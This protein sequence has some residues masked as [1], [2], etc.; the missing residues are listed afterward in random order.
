[1]ASVAQ[2]NRKTMV[3]VHTGE[4]WEAS[5]IKTREVAYT[6]HCP[7]CK[8]RVVIPMRQVHSV[9]CFECMVV[10][11]PPHIRHPDKSAL[12]EPI[13]RERSRRGTR[14]S[15]ES[16]KT[17]V[18]FIITANVGTAKVKIVN[19]IG[20]VPQG[21]YHDLALAL[22]RGLRRIRVQNEPVVRWTRGTTSTREV[23][24]AL[25]PELFAKVRG[26]FGVSEREFAASLELPDESAMTH[27]T[28]VGA[29]EASGKSPSFFLL[30]PDQKF[31]LKTCT[32]ADLKCMLRILRSY[33]DH[34]EQ[35]PDTWI[36]KFMGLYSVHTGGNDITFLVMNN[37]FA[38]QYAIHQKF[39]LK[40][41]TYKRQASARELKKKSP[42][43]KDLDW[44]RSG[45]MWEFKG[46]KAKAMQVLKS[47][48]DFLAKHHL[49]DYSLLVGVSKRPHPSDPLRHDPPPLPVRSLVLRQV[50]EENIIYFGIV[51]ILTPYGPRK[52]LEK[53]YH[54]S[55][56]RRNSGMKSASCTDPKSYAKRFYDFIERYS[57]DFLPETHTVT[58]PGQAK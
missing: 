26:F 5:D 9:Q 18:N 57:V 27:M 31:I 55:L 56:R 58:E 53:F 6:S 50:T 43:Y 11:V 21:V 48:V 2:D 19:K 8:A 33:V 45:H 17:A 25:E 13:R 36:S 54:H 29:K 28:V 3:E 35:H 51:D 16:F 1:M 42:V 47:D 22:Q 7:A 40:G 41:S 15:L 44:I 23:V 52:K 24:R 49:I 10:W 34:V 30:S 20:K 4:T 38:G 39:D 14:S 46:G 12:R 32:W 37:F